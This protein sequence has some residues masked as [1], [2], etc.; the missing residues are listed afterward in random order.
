MTSAPRASAPL[1]ACGALLAALAVLVLA[2]PR[3]TSSS[4]TDLE[5]H[6]RP[7][8]DTPQRQ[9]VLEE[10]PIDVNAASPAELELLPRIG[11]SLAARIVEARER[12]GPFESVDD[13][14]RV[15]GI[16][17]RTVDR[18]RGLVTAGPTR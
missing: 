17:P 4:A 2:Q 15:R 13:L 10:E 5:K 3:P 9:R 6:A 16:G 11:P 8:L 18:L 12:D 1:A 14:G 7:A